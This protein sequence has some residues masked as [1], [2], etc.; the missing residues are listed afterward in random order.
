M[1][2]EDWDVLLFPKDSKVPLKEFKTQCHVV[3]D[4]EFAIAHGSYGLPTMTCFVPGLSTGT[5]FNISLHCWNQPEISQSTTKQ[6]SEHLELVQF[7]ARVFVDGAMV[8]SASFELKGPWPQLI[9]RSFD[10]TKNGE[11]VHLRFPSFR[12]EILKQSYWNPGDNTGRIKIV[13]SEGFPRDSLTLPI[14]RV[15]NVVAFSFQHAPL[16]VLESSSIAWPNPAMWR[17]GP[18]N[19]SMSIPTEHSNDGAEAHTHS[20]H[21]RSNFPNTSFTPSSSYSSGSIGNTFLKTMPNT[22]AF[23]QRESTSS[24]VSPINLDPFPHGLSGVDGISQMDWAATSLDPLSYVPGFFNPSTESKGVR[25][26]RKTSSSNI[27]MPDYSDE[28]SGNF[29]QMDILHEIGCHDSMT[30]DAERAS[31]FL[32]VPTNTPTA[33]ACPGQVGNLVSRPHDCGSPDEGRLISTED[34]SSTIQALHRIREQGRAANTAAS[35][36]DAVQFSDF[37]A[38]ANVNTSDLSPELVATL[39]NSLLNQPILI[40]ASST[41]TSGTG[42]TMTNEVIA[43]KENHLE[44]VDSGF[45]TPTIH[46]EHKDM[47][48]VSQS[49]Y[50]TANSGD[51]HIHVPS[52][53]HCKHE[54][55]SSNSPSSRSLSGIFSN[56]SAYAGDFGQSLTNVEHAPSFAHSTAGGDGL[57]FDIRQGANPNSDDV[58]NN[59]GAS[60]PAGISFGSDMAS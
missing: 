21:R 19:P 22:Q 8:A 42:R 35:T 28:R 49:G 24:T 46:L 50:S 44:E 57:D 53:D 15:K 1:R 3:H 6:F 38:N 41:S 14:E 17:R 30:E 18:Y 40:P 29:K 60:P 16:D 25:E 32:Q 52:T 12:S 2:Y 48:K 11:L 5:F 55:S 36:N 58:S 13:I 59:K 20:P 43:R 4:H 23:L 26:A 27:S 9:S 37:L 51:E 47:R 31:N 7:E 54:T 33:R 10:F 45:N 39:T 34:Y 56:C